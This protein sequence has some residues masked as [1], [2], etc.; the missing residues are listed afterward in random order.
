MVICPADN[1]VGIDC[2]T[3]YNHS[4]SLIILND[5]FFNIRINFKA[6]AQFHGKLFQCQHNVIH[7]RFW[8][9]GPESKISKVHKTIK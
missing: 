7:P 1:N 8:I 6:N 5:Y 2:L 9:P 4:C 3:I